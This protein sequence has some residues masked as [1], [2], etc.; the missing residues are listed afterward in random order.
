[1]ANYSYTALRIRWNMLALD[2]QMTP[3]A[4]LIVARG[5]EK[6]RVRIVVVY[7]TNSLGLEYVQEQTSATSHI[8]NLLNQLLLYLN[9]LKLYHTNHLLIL[10]LAWTPM[11]PMTLTPIA[12]N[13]RR[14]DCTMGDCNATIYFPFPQVN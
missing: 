8:R 9:H 10:A 11:D 2:S 13:R 14:F 3:K 7:A 12:I 5:S 1:V 6:S 4:A